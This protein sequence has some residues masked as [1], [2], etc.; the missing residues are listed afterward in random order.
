MRDEVIRAATR[1]F[2]ERGVRAVS[3]QSI[4]DE[5]GMTKGALY[6]YFSSRDDLLRHVFGDWVSDETEGLRKH[7]ADSGT[8]TAQLRDYV[9]FHVSSIATSLD[10]YSLTF[11]SEAELPDDIRAEFRQL[12]RRS[13]TVLR[14]ILRKGVTEGEFEPRDERVIAFAIDGMCNWLWKWYDPDGPKSADDIADD[15]IELLSRGLLR[16]DEDESPTVVSGADSTRQAAEYHARAIRFHSE[17]LEQL[18]L[19]TTIPVLV[20]EDTTV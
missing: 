15:F 4:A 2:K 6:H 20:P 18:I 3:L 17:R 9:R 7:I 16:R 1:L 13:D 19:A 12:K 11:A 10:L 5:L 8:A 14:G